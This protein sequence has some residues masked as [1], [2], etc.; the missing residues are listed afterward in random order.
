MKLGST[1]I[2]ETAFDDL[3]FCVYSNILVKNC[4]YG[5]IS[6]LLCF[7]IKWRMLSVIK[8]MVSTEQCN[9][10]AINEVHQVGTTIFCVGNTNHRLKIYINLIL[11]S[12]NNYNKILVIFVSYAIEMERKDNQFFFILTQSVCLKKCY[13]R[14]KLI[15]GLVFFF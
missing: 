2:A 7:V 9:I 6:K 11:Y 15:F 1:R 4:L 12:Y 5:P 14:I 8:E 10:N 3:P 13:L